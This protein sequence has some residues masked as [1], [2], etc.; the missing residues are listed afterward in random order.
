MEPYIQALPVRFFFTAM[1]GQWPKLLGYL[2]VSEGNQII[3]EVI[4]PILYLVIRT[5]FVWVW[6]T[7]GRGCNGYSTLVSPEEVSK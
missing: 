6:A 7:K 3:T 2:A 5:T 4:N 1:F